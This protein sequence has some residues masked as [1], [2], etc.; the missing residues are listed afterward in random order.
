MTVAARLG[1]P[2]LSTMRSSVLP[3]AA[4]LVLL[5]LVFVLPKRSPSDLADGAHLVPG[6]AAAGRDVAEALLALPVLEVTEPPA[7]AMQP[8]NDA[9]TRNLDRLAWGG[10]RTI[11]RARES[12]ARDSEGLAQRLLER[13]AIVGDRDPT[14]CSRPWATPTPTPTPKSP[15]SSP[16]SRVARC[17]TAA[18]WP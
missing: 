17:R 2:S 7:W 12:L 11:E 4:I 6:S 9:Q 14:L 8:D 15:E 16:N 3:A 10:H 1:G 13:L 5:G 18:S